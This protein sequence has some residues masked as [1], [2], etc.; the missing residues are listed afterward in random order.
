MNEKIHV[1]LPV[2][3]RREVTRRFISCL[4]SQSYADFH[5]ILIDDG[6]VDGTADMVLQSIPGA[7]VIQGTGSWWWAGS[8]QR[9]F[10]WLLRESPETDAMVL[11]ANDDTTF[12]SDFLEK[13][14]SVLRRNPRSLLLSRI[15]EKE[16]GEVVNSGIHAD[17]KRFVFNLARDGKIINCLSTRG[18]FLRWGDMKDIGGFHSHL[19]PHYWSDYE[20]SIRAHNKGYSCIT[21]ASV[22]LSADTSTTGNRK[23]SQLS[24]WNFLRTLFSPRTIANPLYKTSFVLLA[25]PIRWMIPNFIRIW[26]DAIRDVVS[27]VIV[28]PCFNVMRGSAKDDQR[29]KV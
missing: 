2:H 22:V 24:G 25:V 27:K 19:L 8:L 23:I 14:V 16:S 20:Y 11:I 4:R 7:T 1:L 18:L 15:R 28:A 13:G 5:L 3:D 21:D 10:E 9:A 17:L 26:R 6:S 12:A 29:R